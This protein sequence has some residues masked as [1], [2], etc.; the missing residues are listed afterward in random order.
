MNFTT[1]Y[2]YVK[3]FM[4]MKVKK[5]VDDKNL[6]LNIFLLLFAFIFIDENASYNITS[7]EMLFYNTLSYYHSSQ[8]KC[9]NESELECS[10]GYSNV[11]N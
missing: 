11:G 5:D 8:L 10:L 3:I 2:M 6:L 1:V 4:C 7:R 9:F